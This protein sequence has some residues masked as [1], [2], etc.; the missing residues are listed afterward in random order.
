MDMDSTHERRPTM[1]PTK[2]T[3]TLPALIALLAAATLSGAALAD[4]SPRSF[5]HERVGTPKTRAEV[6]AELQQAQQAGLNFIWDDNHAP[7]LTV[8]ATP[9]TRAEVIAELRE[10][11][12]SGEFERLHADEPAAVRVRPAAKARSTAGSTPTL[13]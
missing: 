12:A 13:R 8:A 3:K 7:V 4:E 9:R 11:Q 1:T 5:E 10:A 6:I 2:T